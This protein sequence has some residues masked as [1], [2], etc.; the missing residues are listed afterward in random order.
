MLKQADGTC[1]SLAN[2]RV[3]Y[4]FQHKQ[5]QINKRTFGSEAIN[6]PSFCIKF[7]ILACILR[8]NIDIV[9]LEK[10][11]YIPCYVLSHHQPILLVFLIPSSGTYFLEAF[12]SLLVSPR[13]VRRVMGGMF[14]ECVISAVRPPMQV[15]FAGVSIYD[16]AYDLYTSVIDKRPPGGWSLY[17]DIL[18]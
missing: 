11:T 9:S 16:T 18:I 13:T 10:R 6:S 8:C 2:T 5:V 7:T 17:R 15:M 4:S 3:S 1:S 14:D 12:L